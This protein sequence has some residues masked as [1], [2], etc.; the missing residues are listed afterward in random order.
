MSDFD[1]N[2]SDHD[3]V[4]NDIMD[5][6]A[7][8]K[9]T[10]AEA[11]RLP[12]KK[13]LEEK[14]VMQDVKVENLKQTLNL[15][16][17]QLHELN[18][19]LKCKKAD[20]TQRKSQ[21]SSYFDLVAEIFKDTKKFSSMAV[22]E[23]NQTFH[24]LGLDIEFVDLAIVKIQKDGKWFKLGMNEHSKLTLID[25]SPRHSCFSEIQILFEETRDV[26]RLFSI[27]GWCLDQ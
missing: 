4:Y 22:H 14:L 26:A 18:E 12:D 8:A 16:T 19:Q 23:I 6:I 13:R 15:K 20:A 17:K 7:H 11:K 5:Q 27:F 10:L 21:R 24:S 25:M 3:D 9:E 2:K 1:R